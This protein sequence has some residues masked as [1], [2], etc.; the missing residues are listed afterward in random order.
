[1][2]PVVVS[3]GLRKLL[4]A[5]LRYREPISYGDFLTNGLLQVFNG[6]KDV[7]GHSTPTH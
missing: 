5:V 4:D 1:V 2:N 6:F 7:L 3:G